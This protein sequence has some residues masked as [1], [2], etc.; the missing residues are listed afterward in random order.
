M[1][2]AMVTINRPLSVCIIILN[3]FKLLAQPENNQVLDR[4]LRIVPCPL[5]RRS[6]VNHIQEQ[7]LL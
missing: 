6:R 7:L 5:D 3:R 1:V 4:L 2:T